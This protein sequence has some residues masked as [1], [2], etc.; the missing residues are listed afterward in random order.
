MPEYILVTTTAPDRKTADAIAKKLVEARSAACV[1]IVGPMTSIY[2][3]EEAIETSEEWLL[4]VK[5]PAAAYE[6]IEA[7]IRQAHP[8]QVPEIAAVPVSRGSSAYLSW[9]DQVTVTTGG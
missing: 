4:L 3:W 8:Y 9:I 5:A 6:R 7:L 2:T 1:Q